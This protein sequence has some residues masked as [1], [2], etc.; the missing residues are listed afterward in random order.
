VDYKDFYH[1]LEGISNYELWEE[2]ID[3]KSKH[4]RLK[5]VKTIWEDRN[6]IYL[7]FDNLFKNF[8]DK[9][10]VV[11]YRAGG[12]PSEE[13]MT[14]LLKRYKKEIKVIRKQYK[15]ALSLNGSK[16]LLFIAT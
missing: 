4:L 14:S 9:I 8:K 16:E 12:V 1:F 3:K 6:E 15:Y 13:E 2:E 5:K 11:S 7:A 10:I